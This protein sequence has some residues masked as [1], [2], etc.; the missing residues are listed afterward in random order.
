MLVQQQS[1]LALN[2]KH[3]ISCCRKVS[4]EI[5]TRHDIIVNILLNDILIQRGLV[6]H[7]QKWEDRKTVKTPTNEIT[8]GTEHWRSDEWQENGES[9][10]RS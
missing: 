8:F 6:S 9:L 7:E 3:I 1:G 5:N 4:A 10:D 2:A